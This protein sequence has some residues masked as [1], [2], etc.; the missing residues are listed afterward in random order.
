MNKLSTFR[1][2]KEIKQMLEQRAEVEKR[3]M[4][5]HLEYLIQQDFLLNVPILGTI[6]N[7]K[8]LWKQREQKWGFDSATKT[9]KNEIELNDAILEEIERRK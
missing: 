1:L 5:A 8:I 2:S 6:K 3:S 7:G 9:E 4:T